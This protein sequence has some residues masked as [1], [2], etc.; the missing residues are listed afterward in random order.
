MYKDLQK[1]SLNIID[2]ITELNV[3]KSTFKI[4]QVQNAFREGF[5]N[6]SNNLLEI[7]LMGDN[8]HQDKK[9]L[10]EFFSV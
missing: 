5:D 4:D 7:N 3:A 10:D 8:S 1:C 2:P 6:I 9:I